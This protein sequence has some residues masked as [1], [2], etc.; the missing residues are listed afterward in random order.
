MTN[1][2]CPTILSGGDEIKIDMVT[3]E[4]CRVPVP[5]NI[6]FH[7]SEVS[8]DSSTTASLGEWGV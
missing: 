3:D 8:D 5:E 6:L 1:S 7:F 2:W 4:S